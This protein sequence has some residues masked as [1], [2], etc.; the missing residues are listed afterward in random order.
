LAVHHARTSGASGSAVLRPPISIGALKRAVRY[1]RMPYERKTSASA[2]A[3]RRY[4]AV[5]AVAS[6]LTFVSTVPLIPSEAFARA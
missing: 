2:A 3:L 1:T 5:S 6:A 4:S